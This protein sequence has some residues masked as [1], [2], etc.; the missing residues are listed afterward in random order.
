MRMYLSFSILNLRIFCLG[1]GI[2]G[3]AKSVRKCENTT[4]GNWV[5]SSSF[6]SLE[7]PKLGQV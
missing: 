3:S 5:V 2:V 6:E 1:S 7:Q 4:R